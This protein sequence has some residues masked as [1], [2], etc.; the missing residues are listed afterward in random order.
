M[1]EPNLS[2]PARRLLTADEVAE[3]WQ[4]GRSHVYAL[5]RAGKIPTVAIGRYYRF[6]LEDLEEWERRGGTEELYS[7]RRD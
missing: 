6:R 5:V 1:R 7:E 2:E 3:R 4:V